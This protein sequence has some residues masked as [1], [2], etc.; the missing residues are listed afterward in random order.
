MTKDKLEVITVG[1]GCFWCVEAVLNQIKGVEEVVSGYMGGTV[2][3]TPTY[4]EICSGLTGH[5]EVVQAKFNPEIISYEELLV[6][7]M[8]SH[9][10]TTLNRQG[11]DVGTQYRSVIFYHNEEQQI[12]AEKIV[13]ELTP[14]YEKTIVTEISPATTFHKAEV[15]HQ[16]F[17][18]NNKDKMYCVVV[19]SPKLAKLKKLYASKLKE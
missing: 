5:A 3:G 16:N 10:P 19:I 13:E 17:Y 14:Y 11:A 7:F 2:P 15:S 8:T 18:E 12:I 6:M 1:G 4:R 9:D